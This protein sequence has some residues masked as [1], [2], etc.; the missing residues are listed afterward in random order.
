MGKTGPV[1]QAREALVLLEGRPVLPNTNPLVALNGNLSWSSLQ[2]TVE[3]PKEGWKSQPAKLFQVTD[4][5]PSLKAS[6]YGGE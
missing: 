6:L 2:H 5:K 4:E 1:T 3:F